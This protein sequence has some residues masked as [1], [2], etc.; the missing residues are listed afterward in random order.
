[1]GRKKTDTTCRICGERGV[2]YGSTRILSRYCVSYSLCHTCGYLQTD[3][4][5]WLEEAYASPIAS[6]DVGVVRRNLQLASAVQALIFGLSGDN[7][8]PDLPLLALKLAEKLNASRLFH[9]LLGRYLAKL[10]PPRIGP[11][12]DYGGGYGLMVRLLRDAGIEAYWQDPHSPNLF[13]RGFEWE[14]AAC[15]RFQLV[16]AFEVWEHLAEPLPQLETMFALGENLLCSTLLLDDPPAR[17][18]KWWYFSPET[19]QHVGFFSGVTLHYLA[20]RLNMHYLCLDRGLHLFTRR[21][22]QL[23]LVK[24]LYQRR[25]AVVVAAEGARLM[26]SL[27]ESDYQEITGR[28]LA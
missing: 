17:P 20:E 21:P 5:Y 16:T 8:A 9:Y 12:L 14:Q 10:R 11:C 2:P 24:Y 25:Q 4:P 13:A 19:G 27:I 3:R 22:P 1:M 15:D 28:A 7:S 18:G 23:G 6:S 26:P